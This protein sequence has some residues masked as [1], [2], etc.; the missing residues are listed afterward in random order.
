[1]SE[2]REAYKV[3][4]LALRVGEILLSS[5]AGAADVTATMLAITEHA[6]LR[7]A[8]VDVTFTALRMGY[9]IDPDEPPLLLSRTVPQRDLDYDDLTRVQGLV[10]DLLRDRIDI[11]EARSRIAWLNSTGHYLPAWAAV[12]VAGVVGGSVS[13]LLDGDLV[14]VGAATLAGMV[15]TVLMRY[16]NRE[17][18]PMFYQQ[19]AGGLVA[20]VLALLT[21]AGGERLG[22]DV[23]TSL[24]ITANIVMLLAG[25]GFLGAV[26]DALTGF[27][28]TSAARIIEALLSTAGLI[29]GVSAGLALAPPLGVSLLGVRPGRIELAAPPVVLLAGIVAACA[30][31]ITCYAPLRALP[32][33][34]ASTTG[35]LLAYLAVYQPSDTQPWAA[36]AAAVVIGV[37]SYGVAGRVRVPPL[38][39]LVPALVPLLPGLTLFRGL[40]YMADGDTMGILQLSAAAATTIALSAGVILGEYVAQPLKRN[41]RRIESR[42]EHRL[43]GPRLIGVTHGQQRRVRERS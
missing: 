22:I 28:L 20:T 23:S 33:V 25:I 36:G 39:V 42:L 14:V 18:W 17:R 3:L 31:A 16:L 27:Y 9:Q 1:M 2:V 38:V 43:A 37:V 32:A 21:D 24:V 13:A 10:N 4:D 5:G 29:A 8:D 34:A 26:Q 40:S 30:F 11:A 6:G 12:V 7:Q 35:G 15:I 41:A 19:A